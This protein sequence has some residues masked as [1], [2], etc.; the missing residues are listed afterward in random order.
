MEY[1]LRLMPPRVFVPPGYQVLPWEPHLLEAHALA[2]FRSFRSELDAQVFPCLGEEA[3]C[4]RL[5]GEI[6][7]RSG[8]VAD[9]TWLAVYVNEGGSIDY[10]GTVQGLRDDMNCGGI[11]NLGVT[12]IHRGIGLGT[13]LLL[14]ALHGFRSRHIDRVYLEVTAKNRTAVRLYRD[15]GFRHVK[16]VYKSIEVALT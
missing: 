9:A 10:C 14:H 7:K 6:A 3:G 5:M 15:M 4:R 8:F 12:P 13:S 2:K 11:Q 16:T 1:S